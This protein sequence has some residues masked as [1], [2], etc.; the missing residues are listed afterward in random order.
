[1]T[2]QTDLDLRNVIDKNAAQ[3]S[4]LLANTYGESGESFRNM[5]DEAQD[6]YMWACADMSNAILTS[7]DELSTRSLA[8]KG[9][10]VQHG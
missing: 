1:M 4:A 9:V 8:R 5:S 2:T 3:L 7:L 6:A 10:E